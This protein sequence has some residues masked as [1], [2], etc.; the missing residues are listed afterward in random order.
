MRKFCLILAFLLIVTSSVKASEIKEEPTLII[1][2]LDGNNFDLKE[3]SGKVIIVN[4]WAKWCV[5][6]RKE[7]LILD[8]IY[9]EY[10]SRNLEIIGINIDHK[11]ERKK[12]SELSSSLSY[13]NAMFIDAKETSFE[14]PNAIPVSYVINKD[15]KLITKIISPDGRELTKQDFENILKPLLK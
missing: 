13:P 5:D 4:F 7:M 9:R 12:V 1:T 3:K 11:R 8:E 14:E 15:G 6:C 10:K 2:T